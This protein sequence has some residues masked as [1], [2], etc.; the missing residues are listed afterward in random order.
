MA[1]QVLSGTGNVSYT[2]TTGQNVRIVINYVSI[3]TGAGD[4]TMTFQGVSVDLQAGAKYGKTLAYSDNW[5]ANTGSS[6]MAIGGGINP[7]DTAVP[8]EIAVAN[9]ETFSITHPSDTTRIDGYNCI[10]IPEAG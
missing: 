2:N 1:A 4:A 6:S 5:G 7:G 10:I 9:G 3:L 8:V